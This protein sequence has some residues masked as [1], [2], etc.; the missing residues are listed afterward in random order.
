MSNVVSMTRMFYSCSNLQFPI[1]FINTARV[2]DMSFTFYQASAFNSPLVLDTRSVK[3]FNSMFQGALAFNSVLNFTDTSN[4]QSMVN[5]FYGATNFNQPL[6]FNTTACQDMNTMFYNA[7]KYNQYLPF[8]TNSV[9]GM[10][11]M[12]YNAYAFNQPLNHFNMSSVGDTSYMFYSALAF[13]QVLDTWDTRSVSVMHYMFTG[14]PFAHNL[15]AW[16]TT[17]TISCNSFCDCCGLPVF[18]GCTPCSGGQ[19]VIDVGHGRKLCSNCSLVTLSPTAL[20]TPSSSAAPT[21]APS[22]ATLPISGAQQAVQSLAVV[23][24]LCFLLLD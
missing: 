4:V 12:F 16:N 5:M 1:N 14:S 9:T 20:P 22:S 2:T 19:T 24:S 3:S 15:A 11:G 21:M 7:E 6:N 23:F 8:V 13:K 17:K 10:Y 18:A